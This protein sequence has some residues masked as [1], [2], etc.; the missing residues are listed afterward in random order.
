M[1]LDHKYIIPPRN[2]HEL[3]KKM[4]NGYVEVNVK[5]VR[6][7]MRVT[8]PAVTDFSTI[9]FYIS[10]ECRGIPTYKLER[11]FMPSMLAHIISL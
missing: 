11:I 10:Q 1:T 7:T 2:L 8:G 5:L 9:G 6:R 4:W 3:I